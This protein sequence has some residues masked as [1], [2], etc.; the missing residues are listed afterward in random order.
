MISATYGMGRPKVQVNDLEALK[1]Y[2]GAWKPYK[3]DESNV[4][5][6]R[7]KEC[8]ENG[9]KIEGMEAF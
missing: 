7:V 6:T 1:Q 4:D 2:P 5:K 9:E 8:L 3:W